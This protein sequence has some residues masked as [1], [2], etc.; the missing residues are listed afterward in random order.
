MCDRG[1]A[2]CGNRNSNKIYRVKER[3]L[4]RG[5]EFNYLLCS[6]C[7]TLQLIDSVDNIGQYY[8]SNYYAYK[9]NADEKNINIFR[10]RLEAWVYLN[11]VTS[12]KADSGFGG[13]EIQWLYPIKGMRIK[14]AAKFWISDAAV[15]RGLSA[16]TSWDIAGYTELIS[17]YHILKVNSFILFREIFSRQKM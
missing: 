5:E 17:L 6:R 4:N 7:G 8:N 2:I 15:G 11:L 12:K 3:M 1:C 10:K 9:R 16:C 14:K 13:A